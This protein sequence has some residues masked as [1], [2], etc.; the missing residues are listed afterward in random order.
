MTKIKKELTLTFG[1]LLCALVS[2]AQN[3]NSIKMQVNSTQSEELREYFNFDGIDFY[4]LKF[5][6]IESLPQ[7]FILTRHEYLHGKLY[8]SDTIVNTKKHQVKNRNDSLK[9]SVMAKKINSTSSK[10]QFNL[11][12]ANIGRVYITQNTD[13]YSLRNLTNNGKKDFKSNQSIDILAYTL[14]YTIA[15]EPDLYY[16][17][18]SDGIPTESWGEKFGVMHYIVFKIEFID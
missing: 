8:K 11:P 17:S 3:N 6:G 4:K 18:F 15:G 5:T 7:Y 16:C 10:F 13:N 9:I 2:L 14:P 1:F 12:I